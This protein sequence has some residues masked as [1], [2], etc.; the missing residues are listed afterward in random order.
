MEEIY[1]KEL[2]KLEILEGNYIYPKDLVNLKPTKHVR[3]RFLER[4]LEMDILPTVVRIT[5]DNLYSGKTQDDKHLHS[6]VVRLF[7][8]YSK[9]MYLCYNPF[10]G[11]LKTVWFRP[12]KRK[13]K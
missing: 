1:E 10:D 13:R 8:S 11:G 7:Y 5:E 4:G 12:T 6:V 3:E 2:T 9:D